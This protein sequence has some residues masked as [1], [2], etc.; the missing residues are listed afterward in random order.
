MTDTIDATATPPDALGDAVKRALAAAEAATDAAHEA[1]AVLLARSDAATA[2]QRTAKRTG[3]L[4]IAASVSAVVVMGLGGLV[5][6]RSGADLR[7]A[8]E[9]QA[10]AATGFIERLA[11]MNGA[12]DRFDALLVKVDADA[13][14]RDSRLNDLLAEL[15]AALAD[16]KNNAGASATEAGSSTLDLDSL[17]AEILAAI[18]ASELSMAERLATLAKT[19]QAVPSTVSAPSAPVAAPAAA[20]RPNRRQSGPRPQ[21]TEPNPFKFP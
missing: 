6:I 10:V 9:V 12:L 15:D 16:Q 7:E 19:T 20:P 14:A 2:M 8:A 21:A 1:E 17:R 11:E 3:W 4:A 13:T 5:W 18:A